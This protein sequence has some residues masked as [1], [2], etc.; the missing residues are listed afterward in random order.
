MTGMDVR[1]T[2]AAALAALACG[3]LAGAAPIAAVADASTGSVRFEI[4]PYVTRGPVT[5]GNPYGSV[6]LELAANPGRRSLDVATLGAR[7]EIVLRSIDGRG[8]VVDEVSI[9]AGIV[10][11]SFAF[12]DLNRD[13]QP[14]IVSLGSTSLYSDSVVVSVRLGL[15]EHQFAAPR[16]QPLTGTAAV[17]ALGDVDGDGWLDLVTGESYGYM[18]GSDSVRVFRG[19]GQGGFTCAFARPCDATDM[20]RLAD[21][22]RDGRAD[23]FLLGWWESEDYSQDGERLRV[24]RSLGGGALDAPFD[25]DTARY[26]R[27]I[28]IGDLDGDEWPD[29]AALAGP[30]WYANRVDAIHGDGL[31]GFREATPALDLSP[32][33]AH[34]ESGLAI[35]DLDGDGRPDLTVNSQASAYCEERSWCVVAGRDPGGA[36]SKWASYLIPG[37]AATLVVGDVDGD[38]DV[39]LLPSSNGTAF[40]RVPP[41]FSILLNRGDGSF[42]G[43]V[44][45]DLAPT[46]GAPGVTAGQWTTG[47]LNATGRADLLGSD[48]TTCFVMENLGRDRW[49]PVRPAALGSIVFVGDLDRDGYDDM[50]TASRDTAWVWRCGGHGEFGLEAVLTG[51]RFFAVADV[52][53]DGTPDV[54]VRDAQGVIGAFRGLGS[55]RFEAP[56]WTNLRSQLPGSLCGFSDLDG[57]GRPD[58][59]WVQAVDGLADTLWVRANRGALAFS[60]S[61]PSAIPRT[62]GPSSHLMTLPARQLGIGDFDSDGRPD[63]AL[64]RSRCLGSDDHGTMAIGLNG[65]GGEFAFLPE[66]DAWNSPADL[67]VAD[68]NRDGRMDLLTVNASGGWTFHFVHH[69][70]LG[71]GEFSNDFYECLHRVQDFPMAIEVGDLDA[72]GLEDV[73]TYGCRWGGSLVFTHNASVPMLPTPTQL[74]LVSATAEGGRVTIEWSASAPGASALEVSRSE[75]GVAWVALGTVSPGSAGTYRWVDETVTPGT[76]YA[77]RLASASGATVSFTPAAWVEVPLGVSFALAGARPNPVR[78]D[79]LLAFSVPSTGGTTLDVLDVTG[80]RV[81]RLEWPALEAGEHRVPL[82]GGLP[83]GVYLLRLARTEGVR[84]ARMVVLR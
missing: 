33:G 74:A 75:D 13:G 3:A 53:A 70:A 69:E 12:R 25:V 37:N 59:A 73:V 10:V 36:W 83:P 64:L 41:G 17:F 67:H 46:S 62:M 6:I 45:L 5:S 7:D 84:T 51:A 61:V 42:A 72:D 24:Y 19:D 48:G 39:D 32:G 18:G 56:R 4:A 77:Y 23:V 65:G 16:I 78:G 22:D 44:E 66:W 43:Q 68:L 2:C 40:T 27:A 29:I 26:V 79:A 38:G 55:W 11:S 80:R 50:V 71:G 63:V 9:D 60:D 20:I 35:A 34:W 57:D 15:D 81:R 47:R 30:D 31:G 1:G 14:D 76:R 58:F 21:F 82:T 8:T 52:D 54:V 49:A 28:D